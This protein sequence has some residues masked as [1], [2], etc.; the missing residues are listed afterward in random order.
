MSRDDDTTIN[1]LEHLKAGYKTSLSPSIKNSLSMPVLGVKEAVKEPFPEPVL[2]HCLAS[3]PSARNFLLGSRFSPL[4]A[5]CG[6]ALAEEAP[7]P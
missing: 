4:E 6:S 3:S 2:S 7:N 1:A 5:G